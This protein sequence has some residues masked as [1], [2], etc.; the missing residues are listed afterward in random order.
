MPALS[1]AKGRGQM[2]H[3]GV[4][5]T[6]LTPTRTRGSTRPYLIFLQE[7]RLV[8]VS[9]IDRTTEPYTAI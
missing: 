7:T 6:Q 4:L 9:S 3:P 2:S 5:F 8:A 1:L